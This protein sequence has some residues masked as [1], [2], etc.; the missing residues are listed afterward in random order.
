M[1]RS[2]RVP[3]NSEASRNRKQRHQSNPAPVSKKDSQPTKTHHLEAATKE[4]E[5]NLF[6]VTS[7]TNKPLTV[8]LSFNGANLIMEIDTGPARSVISEK[9][10]TQL[11]PKDLQLQLKPTDAALKTYTGETINP[12]GVISV[13]VNSQQQ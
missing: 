6:T 1:C 3:A 7:S 12:L 5:Y 13:Q 4:N 11:W 9:T 10:F 8:S 2:A